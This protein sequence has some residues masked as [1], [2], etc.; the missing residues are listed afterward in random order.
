MPFL[1]LSFPRRYIIIRIHDSSSSI[2]KSTITGNYSTALTYILTNYISASF[3]TV[4][5]GWSLHWKQCTTTE[6]LIRERAADVAHGA[7]K[8]DRWWV[9]FF[10]FLLFSFT[11]FPPQKY[12]YDDIKLPPYQF[13]L[14]NLTF[15]CSKNFFLLIFSCFKWPKNSIRL[16]DGKVIGLNT[17]RSFDSEQS[18]LKDFSLTNLTENLKKI[19]H[20]SFVQKVVNFKVKPKND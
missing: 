19:F 6:R 18:G 5:I 3:L 17:G 1:S 4:D 14:N 15:F 8:R 10:P 12:V 2:T 16:I 7:R 9:Q 11:L 13:L 20:R